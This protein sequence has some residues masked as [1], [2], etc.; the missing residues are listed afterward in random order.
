MDRKNQTGKQLDQKFAIEIGRNFILLLKRR[1]F[2]VTRAFLYG[3][4]A[5]GNPREDS[6]IDLA[7]FLY[8]LNDVFEMQV[9]MLKLTWDFDTRIEP[10]PFHEE[11]LIQRGPII[12]EIIRTGIEI[13]A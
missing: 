3:S 4:Y 2:P 8:P 9:E 10:H 1:N 7:I 11:E 5:K 12:E 13:T 6:D